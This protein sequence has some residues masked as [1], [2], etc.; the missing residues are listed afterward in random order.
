MLDR[1]NDRDAV[2]VPTDA[3]GNEKAVALLLF[4]PAPA[5]TMMASTTSRRQ[6]RSQQQP[7]M[8]KLYVLLEQ[9]S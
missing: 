1:I 9:P 2:I 7:V 6:G 5:K 4:V 3:D 8:F